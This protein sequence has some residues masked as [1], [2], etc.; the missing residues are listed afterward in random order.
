MSSDVRTK[1]LYFEGVARNFPNMSG[2]ERA[3]VRKELIEFYDSLSPARTMAK[4]ATGG[5]VAAGILPGIGW[6]AGGLIGGVVGMVKSEDEAVTAARERLAELI[7][8][9]G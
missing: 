6:I 2:E 3:R 4:Y 5:A 1:V 7:E 8:Q 9:I